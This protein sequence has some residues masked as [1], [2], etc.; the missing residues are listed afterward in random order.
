[1]PPGY[2][3]PYWGMPGMPMQPMQGQMMPGRMPP[4]F[5]MP[6]QFGMLQQQ[7]PGIKGGPG[8]IPVHR[9]AGLQIVCTAISKAP[10]CACQR[11]L[12]AWPPFL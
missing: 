12:S 2:G 3:M 11:S 10:D 1:M 4:T 8:N 7:L 9:Q 5:S 6:Q